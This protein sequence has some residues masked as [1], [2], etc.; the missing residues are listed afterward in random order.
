MDLILRKGYRLV[1]ITGKINMPY[2]SI[3]KPNSKKNQAPAFQ[4]N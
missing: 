4:A 1:Q 3:N 2:R